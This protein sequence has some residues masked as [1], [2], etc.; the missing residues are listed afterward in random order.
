M[1]HCGYYYCNCHCYQHV[2]NDDW[3]FNVT[4]HAVKKHTNISSGIEITSLNCHPRTTCFWSTGRAELQDFRVLNSHKSH[5]VTNAN[6]TSST[7]GHWL[8]NSDLGS[9]HTQP[10]IRHESMWSKLLQCVKKGYFKQVISKEITSLEIFSPP[11]QIGLGVQVSASFQNIPSY[12]S[13][14]VSNTD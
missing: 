4:R 2:W 13:V 6:I 9:V 1:C 5:L 3:P 7:T 8:R 12:G 10:S 11:S 14:R